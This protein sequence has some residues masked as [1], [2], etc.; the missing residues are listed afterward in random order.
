MKYNHYIKLSGDGIAYTLL[1]LREKY[2]DR[3]TD[4]MATYAIG[5]C[6]RLPAIKW[7]VQVK[8]EKHCQ[9]LQYV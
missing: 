1:K 5:K 4:S 7:R 3:W 2:G 8:H 6:R 9:Q